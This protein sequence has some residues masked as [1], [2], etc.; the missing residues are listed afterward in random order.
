MSSHPNTASKPTRHPPSL[1]QKQPEPHSDS[2]D[3]PSDDYCYSRDADGNLILG[4]RDRKENGLVTLT[5]R[6]IAL[7]KKA[8]KQTLDLNQAV[9]QLQV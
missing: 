2:S 5:H 8:P 6:F 1:R 3:E 7:L 4:K 9:N